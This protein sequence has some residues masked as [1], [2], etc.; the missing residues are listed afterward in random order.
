MRLCWIQAFSWEIVELVAVWRSG[1][2]SV[3]INEV[4]L[5]LAPLVLGWV[6]VSGFNSRCGHLF[7]YVTSHSGQLS[8]AIPSWVSTNQR[9]MTPCGWG[10]KAGMVRVWVAG[11]TVWSPCYTRAISEHFR[12]KELIYKALYKFA[13]FALPYLLFLLFLAIFSTNTFVI[14]C[15]REFCKQQHYCDWKRKVRIV[16]LHL[17]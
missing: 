15:T 10:V 8:L 12:D 13:F 14:R 5:H 1:S 16:V 2:A 7:R 17:N 11:K 9:A 3:S 6:T 4:N